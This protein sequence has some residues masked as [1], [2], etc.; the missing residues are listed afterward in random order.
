MGQPRSLCCMQAGPV[1][2][3]APKSPLPLRIC[4]VPMGCKTVL[5]AAGGLWAQQGLE[6]GAD[7]L[8]QDLCCSSEGIWCV[9]HSSVWTKNVLAKASMQK[10]LSQRS[11]WGG[12]VTRRPLGSGSTLCAEVHPHR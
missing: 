12:R 10:W 5:L 3:P 8:V 6:D 1:L 2:L 9:E 11:C 4:T 7:L